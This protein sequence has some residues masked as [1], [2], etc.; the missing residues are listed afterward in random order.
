VEEYSIQRASSVPSRER[1]I[2]LSSQGW[3]LVQVV[4]Y[5][6]EIFVYLKCTWD[7]ATLVTGRFEYNAFEAS[8]LLSE[9]N[10]DTILAGGWELIQL[11]PTSSKI[12][13]YTRRLK[14]P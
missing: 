2:K 14:K 12:Y 5:K 6:G 13:V 3:E 9:D 1:L 7:G 10:L 4:C 8:S 11:I